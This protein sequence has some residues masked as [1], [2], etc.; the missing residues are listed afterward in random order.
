MFQL[1]QFTGDISNWDVSNVTSMN[2]MFDTSEF[3]GDISKWKIHDRCEMRFIFENSEFNGDIID[4]NI[5]LENKITVYQE[6]K[7]FRSMSRDLIQ[8]YLE[9]RMN[10]VSRK[11]AFEEY[12]GAM[13]MKKFGF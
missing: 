13:R 8:F 1:S 6:I 11:Q 4:W 2:R 9:L 12:Y 7:D 3:N 10:G 5:P